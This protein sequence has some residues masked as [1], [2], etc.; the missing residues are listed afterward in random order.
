MIETIKRILVIIPTGKEN[1]VSMSYL[2]NTL[3]IP[4]REVR[5]LVNEVRLRKYPVCGDEHG[6]YYPESL[7]ELNDYIRRICAHRDTTSQVCD[8]MSSKLSPTFLIQA[9][10]ILESQGKKA[11]ALK[12]YQT[13]KEK[14]FNS[15]AYQTIDA[16]I[17]RCS[18]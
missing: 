3:E 4:Q 2:A 5:F 18:E 9:G 13:V 11:D 8:S 17:E 16:Y 15:M 14:Y 1:G 12:L 10:E 6:Y 7:D